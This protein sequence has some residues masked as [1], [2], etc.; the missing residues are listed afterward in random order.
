MAI[1]HTQLP[2]DIAGFH[3]EYLVGQALKEFKDDNFEA[4][5]QVDYLPAVTDLD[6]I[7]FHPEAGFFLLETKGMKIDQI[8]TYSLTEFILFPTTKKQHPV[9]QVRTGQHRLKNFLEDLFR[10]RDLTVRVPFIQTSVVWPQITR[11]AWIK[12]FSDQRVQLQAKSMIFKD[13]LVTPKS[14]LSRLRLL[15]D[16]PLLGTF[17]IK[18]PVP[19]E[20][21]MNAVREALSPTGVSRNKNDTLADEIRR[22]VVHSK[23]LALTYPPPKKYNV[24]FEGPP[25][26]GKSTV[27][28]EIGLLHAAAGGTVLHVCYNKALA[29]DQRREYEVLKTQGI[30]YGSIDVFDEWELYKAVHP[31]WDAY[32]GL[33]LGRRYKF[34]YE[35]AQE[36][37][38]SRGKPDSHPTS[39]YDTILIDEAQ[40]LSES[41]F[42]VLEYLARPSASWFTS[43][44]EGQ[45][46]F[47]F[48]KENPS[49]HLKNWLNQ[50]ERKRLKRS[51]RNSTRAFLMAQNFWENYPYFEKCSDWFDQKLSQSKSDDSSMELEL[52]L[53]T[54]TN[55]FRVTRLSSPETRLVSIKQ[56]LLE[57]IES[58]RSARRG[59]DVLIVV[60]DPHS[61]SNEKS[62][63]NYELVIEVLDELQPMLSL[64]VLDLIPWENRRNTPKEGTIRI[65]RYQGIRGLSASHVILFDFADL[66]AWCNQVDPLTSKKKGPLNNYGYIAFSRSR[67]STTIVLEDVSN[68]LDNFVES[69]LAMVREKV[70]ATMNVKR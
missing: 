5:F 39:I 17:S 52:E 3:G 69:S 33:D 70:L 12:Q 26:T 44:G 28:R 45:E 42:Q 11:S 43:Y 15:R 32:T 57:V 59:S 48:N 30:E 19:N 51:F 16:Y 1:F 9:E 55:D 25:G 50:A 31:S 66:E 7:I 22:A 4:W 10:R 63:T 18:D 2:E 20:E 61:K 34:G 58:A 62:K 27:L 41:I 8:A 54:D 36:I 49:P 60:G 64:D 47:F 68:P 21:A 13:D 53:P 29:A 37:V 56:L 40:D 46:I 23:Q 67:V 35:V 65:A 14:L 38:D 24:S 6:S